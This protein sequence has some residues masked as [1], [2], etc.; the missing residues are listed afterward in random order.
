MEKLLL[1]LLFSALAARAEV[2]V[3]VHPS[4]NTALNE[5]NIHR[6]FL[7][8]QQAFADGRHAIVI[9]APNASQT[10]HE[11]NRR[12]LGKSQS[13][14]KAYWARL[15]FTGKG[16][17]PRE[18]RSESDVVELVASNPNMIGYVRPGLLSPKVR[19]VGRY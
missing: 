18:A 19:V 3:V 1:V 12:V 6:L 2:A 13:Q 9:A 8:K 7:G 14:L 16:A 17:P 4:N 15:I 11:F 5:A 10:H